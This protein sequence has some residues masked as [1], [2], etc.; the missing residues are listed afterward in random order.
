MP[1]IIRISIVHSILKEGR[2][3]K[4]DVLHFCLFCFGIAAKID[5]KC[6][7]FSVKQYGLPTVIQIVCE[8]EINGVR[9]F[10]Y[11]TSTQKLLNY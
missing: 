2:P 6:N 5:W 10:E 11:K 9:T 1:Q 8:I 4:S 3:L 7:Y